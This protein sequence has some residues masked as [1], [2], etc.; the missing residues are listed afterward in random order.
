M[1]SRDSCA[2]R[3]STRRENHEPRAARGNASA[4][5]LRANS[6]GS[7]GSKKRSEHMGH[8][9]AGCGWMN[10]HLSAIGQDCKLSWTP[11]KSTPESAISIISSYHNVHSCLT[12]GFTKVLCISRIFARRCKTSDSTVLVTTWYGMSQPSCKDVR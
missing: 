9:E 7:N 2:F 11:N 12:A 5:D 10:K 1:A 8:L 3:L 4:M 6:T